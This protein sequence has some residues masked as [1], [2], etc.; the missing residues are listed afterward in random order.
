[1]GFIKREKGGKQNVRQAKLVKKI[2]I[3]SYGGRKYL[4]IALIS[5]R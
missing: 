2:G 5:N 1:M 3:K 4:Q